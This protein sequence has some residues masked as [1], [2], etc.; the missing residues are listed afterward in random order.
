MKSEK[1]TFAFRLADRSKTDDTKWA[2][3][4]GP[5]IAGCSEVIRMN[6]REGDTGI[7]C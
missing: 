7:Y 4:K 3:R 6:Y 2:A 5:A 1:T